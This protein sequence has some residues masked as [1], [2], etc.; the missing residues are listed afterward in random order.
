MNET[1]KKYLIMI[2]GAMVIGIGA[3]FIVGGNVG[4]DS[5]T[6][7]EQGLMQTCNIALPIA[8]ILANGIFVILLLIFSRENLSI[9]TI[10]CPLFISLGSNIGVK[11]I[12]SVEGMVVRI[13]FLLVGIVICALGIGIGAQTT[14]GSNPYDGFVLA[15]SK[16]INQSYSIVRPVF[17][18]CLLVLGI[19]LHG[20]FGIGTFIATFCIGPVAN[21]FIK[22]LSKLIN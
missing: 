8:M 21:V 20:T 17:D 19:L 22:G 11:F 7:F 14:T 16:K 18:V 10:L 6:T 12:P 3:A 5:M 2:V 13:I 9:D 1:V 4:G 15:F